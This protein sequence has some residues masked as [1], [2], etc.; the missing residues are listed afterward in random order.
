MYHIKNIGKT[1]ATARKTKNMTQEEL[2]SGL[3]ISAQA[4][5]KWENGVGL[6]DLTLLP[7]I[8]DVLEL[9]IEAL[10]GKT[11]EAKAQPKAVNGM[12]LI[13]QN[14]KWALYSDKEVSGR[15]GDKIFFADG[16]EA[17]MVSGSVVNCGAGEVRFR[18]LQD[19]GDEMD[20]DTADA[21]NTEMQF[22]CDGVDSIRMERSYPCEVEICRGAEG[23]QTTLSA[24]GSARFIRHVAAS[25]EEKT[26]VVISDTHNVGNIKREKNKV[27]ILTG[28]AAGDALAVRVD[29]SSDVKNEVFFA[30]CRVRVNGSGDVTLPDMGDVDIRISG[31]GDVELGNVATLVTSIAGS[32]NVK[33]GNA[34]TAQCTVSGSGD[35]DAANIGE[36][37]CSV[38][39]S[40][41]VDAGECGTAKL[42]VSGSGEMKFARITRG[43]E[44][45]VS[46]SGSMTCPDMAGEF[47]AIV[48]GASEISCGGDLD[49]L[50]LSCS[51]G[52]D[53]AGEEL[54]VKEASI[55]TERGGYSGIVIGR[56]IG[57][58]YEKI[59]KDTDL[60]VICRG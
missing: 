46:G 56:I 16:S 34:S 29:G 4:I 17:D 9:P 38:N 36:F 26:L 33:F 2:A 12:S 15:E 42:S 21:G 6:P 27:K 31:S 7:R 32:G 25:C 30:N 22:A 53:F 13:A 20:D 39:G 3:N 45:S 28:F 18:T 23:A 5:S 11:N 19:D 37:V 60:K 43:A 35:I 52:C 47:T 57:K 44:L 55:T 51:G 50:T 41:D 59:S 24:T 58:S 54:T 48:S 1:I 10:F 8:A 14:S 49:K 40:G